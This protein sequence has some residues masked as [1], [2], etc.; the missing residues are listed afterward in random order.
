VS[1]DRRLLLAALGA[2]SVV[3]ITMLAFAPYLG[4]DEAQY[5]I[6]ARGDRQWLYVS[7]GTIAIARAGIALGASDVAMRVAPALLG[8]A[9]VIATW[10]VGRVA[11][12]A[13]SGAVAAAVM[14]GAHPLVLRNTELIG[15]LPAAAC[16]L[17]GIALLVRE[18]ERADGPSWWIVA[19]A[20]AF[21]AA[22]YIR[23][24]HAP[25]I[26]IAAF[27]AAAAWWRRVL[28]RPLPI[29]ATLA[30]F[31]LLLVPYARH[32]LA[33]TG[34][35]LGVLE[36]YRGMPGDRGGLVDYVASNPI[37]MYG[38][39]VVPLLVAGAYAIGALRTRVAIVLG[40][41]A[42]GQFAV[43]GLT[44]PAQPR[45]VCVASALL[46]VLG[47]EVASRSLAD[48]PRARLVALAAIAGSWLYCIVAAVPAAHRHDRGRAPLAAA[49][50]A[51]ERD[52]AGRPCLVAGTELP[53]VMWETR[54]AGQWAKE[55]PYYPWPRE[56]RH[57][58]VSQGPSDTVDI[59][60]IA[61]AEHERA[62]ELPLASSGPVRAWRL[63]P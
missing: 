37:A 19:V 28:A 1:R 31:A 5:A 59:A 10:L 20:P 18:L 30:A 14:A 63:D 25:V 6:A 45:Y 36:A 62:V 43:V 12:G 41:I 29:V 61:A 39:L 49:A 17:V 13:R 40:A 22:F 50:E 54:C 16:L 24:V 38:A 21:A 56:L 53:L 48:R 52:A 51:I 9:F 4:H 11:F 44:G 15:D 33:E 42:L 3:A 23:Y 57:Y 47:V 2:W 46:V 58:V 32:S 7:P 34:S 27:A 55:P 26:A 35:I 8:L 60:A